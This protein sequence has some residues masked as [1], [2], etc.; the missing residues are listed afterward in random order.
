ME[1]KFTIDEIKTYI[2]S[3]DSLGDVIYNLS[4]DNIRK[5]ITPETIEGCYRV[6]ERRFNFNSIRFDDDV[7]IVE[8]DTCMDDS[9]DVYN[10]ARVNGDIV[11]EALPMLE[12]VHLEAHKAYAITGFK[13]K[14]E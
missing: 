13:L 7:I 11:C 4:A 1:D 2:M 9:D 10:E 3:Q 12:V 5:S 8:E 6:I 14:E